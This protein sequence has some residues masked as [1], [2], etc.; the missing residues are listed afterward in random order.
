VAG[1]TGRAGRDLRAAIGVGVALAVLIVASLFVVKTVFV[2]VVVLAA[3]LA[4]WELSNA[5]ATGPTRVPLVPVS[6]GGVAMLVGAYYGGTEVLS[7]ALVLS[8]IGCLVW[9]LAESG[10]GFVRDATAGV[11]VLSYVPLLGGFVLLMLGEEDGP[12]R[13]A[14]FV[15]VTAASDT[16]G[17]AVGALLG[18]HP[19]APRISPKKSWEGFAGSVVSCMLVGWLAV[20]YALDGRWW[21]GVLLGLA[22]AVMATLGDLGESLIKRDLGIKDM[23]N[24]L[25]GHG[26]IMDRLDS[27]LAVAP[28]AWLILHTLVG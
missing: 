28:V 13:V 23:G 7:V 1:R 11:L 24:L 12:W 25:P 15:L 3:L 2:G 20:A 14:T 8:V 9:R 10:E 21:V 18:R 16:G 19:M 4:I 26:G 5:L 27:L 22:A 17:Y 6:V